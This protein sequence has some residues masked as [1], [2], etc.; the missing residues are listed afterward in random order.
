MAC[1][2]LRKSK[3]NPLHVFTRTTERPTLLSRIS[4]VVDFDAEWR[5]APF[6][7]THD[8]AKQGQ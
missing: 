6:I 3:E 4:T 1:L 7:A 5:N 8:N 2:C